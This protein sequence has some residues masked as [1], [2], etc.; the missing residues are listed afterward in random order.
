[1][2]FFEQDGVVPEPLLSRGR[3]RIENEVRFPAPDGTEERDADDVV[4][5]SVGN[6]GVDRPI[7]ALAQEHPAELADAGAGVEDH[8]R[9]VG[10]TDVDAD[11][12]ASVTHGR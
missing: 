2:N 3:Q 10:Q 4:P 1:M 11:R 8:H 12:V 6:Q 9:T 7:G 5:M